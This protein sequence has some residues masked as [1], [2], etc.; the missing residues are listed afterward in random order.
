MGLGFYVCY[1]FVCLFILLLLVCCLLFI[2]FVGHLKTTAFRLLPWS[3]PICVVICN[4]SRKMNDVEIE[5][6]YGRYRNKHITS[7]YAL[8]LKVSSKHCACQLKDVYVSISETR[9]SWHGRIWR[10]GAQVKTQE[11]DKNLKCKF[12]SF[13][14][15]FDYPTILL[16]G[17]IVDVLDQINNHGRPMEE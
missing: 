15:Y 7:D 2:L 11:S 17:R 6:Q 3:Q 12:F 1:L 10:G 16:C 5:R 8:H 13:M 9:T 4:L 14:D